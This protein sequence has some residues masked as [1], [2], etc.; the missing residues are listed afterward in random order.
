MADAFSEFYSGG[1]LA[2]NRVNG[3]LVP[4]QIYSGPTS[5]SEMYKGIYADA[6]SAPPAISQLYDV[7]ND[8]SLPVSGGFKSGT[9][10]NPQ[11]ATQA[12]DAAVPHAS[13]TVNDNKLAYR[14][15][16]DATLYPKNPFQTS[17]PAQ[18]S[19]N[20]SDL[21]AGLGLAGGALGGL[22]FG[23]AP[24]TIGAPDLTGVDPWSGAR[25]GS[26]P[27]RRPGLTTAAPAPAPS[28][29]SL[30]GGVSPNDPLQIAVRA[31]QAEG[32]TYDRSR[33]SSFNPNG[34]AHGGSLAGF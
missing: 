4:A 8:P 27:A 9:W 26:A 28:V 22:N 29:S 5:V 10:A 30:F 17:A 14:L 15:S 24:N 34:G 20:I 31:A 21:F 13:G 2:P 23:G 32:Q 12:I 11:T 3:T 16:G 7:A 18:Q 6:P 25:I 33:D 1:M 19:R